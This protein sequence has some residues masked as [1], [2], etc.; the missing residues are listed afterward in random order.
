MALLAQVLRIA[1]KLKSNPALS[2]LKRGFMITY[3]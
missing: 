3:T 2:S 1:Q